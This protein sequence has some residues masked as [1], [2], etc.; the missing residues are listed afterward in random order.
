MDYFPF[1]IWDVILPILP[2]SIIFQRAR[3]LNHQAVFPSHH[4]YFNGIFH[5]LNHPYPFIDGGRSTSNQKLTHGALRFGGPNRQMYPPPLLPPLR[6]SVDVFERPSLQALGWPKDGTATGYRVVPW[7]SIGCS[8]RP[9]E[10][11]KKNKAWPWWIYR[12]GIQCSKQ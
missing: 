8:S 9:T 10:L 3:W 4:P 7:W 2:K 11:F 6:G 1:H 12:K 5:F